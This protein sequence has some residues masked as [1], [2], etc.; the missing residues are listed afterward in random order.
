M[1]EMP[2]PRRRKFQYSLRSLCLVMLLACIGMS[3]L[4]D[5]IQ[6]ARRQREIVEEIQKVG[7]GA[8]YDYQADWVRTGAQPLSPRW[9]RHLLGDD[10]FWNVDYVNFDD[11]QVTGGL[12]WNT[13]RD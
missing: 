8:Y 12:G 10:F 9:L 2:R 1:N 13:S 5:K 3:W 11:T 6:K 7:G 4:G